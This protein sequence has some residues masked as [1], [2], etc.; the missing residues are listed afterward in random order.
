MAGRD[1]SVTWLRVKDEDIDEAGELRA[2]VSAVEEGKGEKKRKRYQCKVVL[3]GSSKEEAVVGFKRFA[4]TLKADPRLC[5]DAQRDLEQ[6]SLANFRKQ[7]RRREDGNLVDSEEGGG[8]RLCFSPSPLL[9]ISVPIFPEMEDIIEDTDGCG[10][11][12]QGQTN[13]GRVARSASGA[14]G[15]RRKSSISV[16]G[17][18]KNHSDHEGH[19]MDFNL[20]ELALSNEAPKAK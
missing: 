1:G 5:G 8:K 2:T 6:K 17:H 20:K 14:I 4:A 9:G 7:K 18:G 16:P 11:Q 12:F 19:T 3:H 15:V 10:S 13:A